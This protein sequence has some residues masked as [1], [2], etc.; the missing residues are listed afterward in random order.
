MQFFKKVLIYQLAIIC[1]LFGM[2]TSVLAEGKILEAEFEPHEELE[3]ILIG[4]M[5]SREKIDLVYL[6]HIKEKR[7]NQINSCNETTLASWEKNTEIT[8]QKLKKYRQMHKLSLISRMGLLPEGLTSLNLEKDRVE[9]TKRAI[10]LDECNAAQ[11]AFLK[12]LYSEADNSYN[13]EISDMWVRKIKNVNKENSLAFAVVASM[14]EEGIVL[15]KSERAANNFYIIACD[16]GLQ[17]GCDQHRRLYHYGAEAKG[18]FNVLSKN[19]NKER[20]IKNYYEQ[21]LTEDYFNDK[22]PEKYYKNNDDFVNDIANIDSDYKKSIGYIESD[23][24]EADLINY[25][26]SK[27]KYDTP[28]EYYIEGDTIEISTNPKY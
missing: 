26:T 6:T 17:I 24:T 22:I 27:A 21:G 11:R 23:Y 3:M 18:Y 7:L 1:I 25:N 2:Q 28:A 20:L 12:S 4:N 16:T 9:W 5:P 8:Q 15:I 13:S 14:Y 10:Q 19:Y